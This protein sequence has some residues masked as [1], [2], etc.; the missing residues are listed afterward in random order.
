MD[1]RLNIKLKLESFQK[2]R[3]TKFYQFELEKDFLDKMPK[4]SNSERKDFYVA[5]KLRALI[6]QQ[7]L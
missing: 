2:K 6:H 1:C 4:D 3:G 7:T 5:F